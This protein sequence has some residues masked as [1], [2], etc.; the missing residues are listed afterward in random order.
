MNKHV[1][2]IFKVI[3]YSYYHCD[4]RKLKYPT[5]KVN[6]SYEAYFKSIG[7]VEDYM[8][9]EAERNE[10]TNL[11]QFPED[12]YVG[13]YAYVVMEVPLGF[14]VLEDDNLSIRIYLPDGTL[15]G[16]KP[17]ASFFPRYGLDSYGFNEWGRL[18]QFEGREP[19]EIKFKPGDIVEIFGYKGNHYWS[20]DEVNLAIVVGTPHTVTEVAKMR[21]QYMATHNGFDVC[22]HRL[23]GLF[24]IHLDTYEVLSPGCDGIDHASTISVF[25]PSIQVSA[26]REK[27]LIEM[28]KKY[29]K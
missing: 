14:E 22:N 18:N 1:D 27:A 26:S 13:M 11:S 2:S 24:G 16:I 15:W 7:E 10:V 12:H 21:R 17:Y 23:C 19:E 29:G 8:R 6:R 4:S 25:K 9:V 5:F 3:H 20:D 28:Y